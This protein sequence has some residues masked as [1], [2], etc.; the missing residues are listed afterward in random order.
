MN[1]T[2]H[3]YSRVS[4]LIQEEEGTSLDN[5]KQLGIKKAETLGFSYKLWNEGGQSSNHDDLNNRPVLVSLLAQIE[6]GNVKHLFVY[7]TD[8]LSRNQKT[9]SVIRYKLLEFGVTLYTNSGQ[10]KLANPIDDLMLGILSEISQYDNRIRS[11]RSRLGR[12]QKIQQ[13][14][15]KGGPPPFGFSIK[16]KKLV[17]DVFES[18]WVKKIFDWY[19]SGV[20]VNEIRRRLDANGVMTRRGNAKWSCGSI[21]KILYNPIYMGYYDYCDKMIGESVRVSSPAIIEGVIFDLAQKR[22]GAVLDKKKQLTKTKHFYLLRDLLVCGHCGTPMG[23][24]IVKRN[25]QNMYYCVKSERSWKKR[26]ADHPKWRRGC[27]CSLIHSVNIKKTDRL[28]CDIVDWTLRKHS[29]FKLDFAVSNQNGSVSFCQGDSVS[30]AENQT[31]FASIQNAVGFDAEDCL[32]IAANDSLQSVRVD[33]KPFPPHLHAGVFDVY[34]GARHV[35]PDS[36]GGSLVN[37]MNDVQKRD[38]LISIISQ[39]RV[40]YDVEAGCHWLEVEF[41][42]SL[43]QLAEGF[44]KQLAVSQTH[45]ESQRVNESDQTDNYVSPSDRS[46]LLGDRGMIREMRSGSER[47]CI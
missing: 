34:P 10:L 21:H 25:H 26:G 24:R 33:K 5:Q 39:V 27:E 32:S 43:G 13:G 36:L 29:C 16:N 11:E 14:N 40:H 8:R 17:V 15:W 28:V 31:Q 6:L 19:N 35:Q 47:G 12:F 37:T 45:S 7:N 22:R 1:N 4:S 23:G 9:W 3:I 46:R 41:S 38:F 2:L 18:E 20:A 30:T 44:M 42:G